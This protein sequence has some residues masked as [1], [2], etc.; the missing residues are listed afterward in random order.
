MSAVNNA[1]GKTALWVTGDL[2][3]AV[4]GLYLTYVGWSPA[5]SRPVSQAPTS[6]PDLPRAA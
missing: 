6:T 5:P 4:V 1:V 2:L 3:V